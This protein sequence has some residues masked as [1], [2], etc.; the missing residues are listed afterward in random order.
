MSLQGERI[1]IIALLAVCTLC[2]TNPGVLLSVPF[3]ISP[4]AL[5]LTLPFAIGDV[6]VSNLEMTNVELREVDY[7][8]KLTSAN[9][10][11][12]VT[13]AVV[14][15]DW[16]YKKDKGKGFFIED[17]LRLELLWNFT[18]TKGNRF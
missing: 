11:V 3:P 15:F 1:I 2:I 16:F 4:P 5:E 6:V 9:A 17:E 10:E 13:K 18:M 8:W 7:A 14:S 12:N